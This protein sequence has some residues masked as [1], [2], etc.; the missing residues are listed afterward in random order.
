LKFSRTL[1]ITVAGASLLAMP[2]IAR[3]ATAPAPPVMPAT[4]NTPT[5]SNGQATPVQPDAPNSSLQGAAPGTLGD[6]VSVLNN[7]PAQVT[8]L[9]GLSTVPVAN[10]QLV[11]VN[12]LA[13][14]NSAS[15]LDKAI[16][17]NMT[18]VTTM[19]QA[20]QSV[21]VADAANKS[22]SFGDALNNISTANKLKARSRSIA[23]SRST[24]RAGQA[25]WSS[26]SASR[27]VLRPASARSG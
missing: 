21:Q 8:A 3:A 15:A 6:F 26:T 25:R 19:R 12:S 23:S 27:L 18:D 10:I 24:L 11:D 22:M 17:R 1:A 7:Q 5:T 4:P 16:S 14:G 13:K 9:K 20:L 2:A